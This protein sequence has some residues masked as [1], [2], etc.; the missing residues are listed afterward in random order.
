MYIDD[1]NN[2]GVW[3]FLVTLF[4]RL[5]VRCRSRDEQSR[6]PGLVVLKKTCTSVDVFFCLNIAEYKC[7]PQLRPQSCCCKLN[8]SDAR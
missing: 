3:R 2:G 5:H 7:I 1:T 6:L 8:Q 4:Q